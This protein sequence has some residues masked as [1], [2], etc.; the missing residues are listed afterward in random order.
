MFKPSEKKS[1]KSHQLINQIF[2]EKVEDADKY[3]V[4]YAYYMKRGIFSQ[5]MY[6]YIIGFSV[7]DKEIIVIPI[8]S[9]TNESGDAIN[10]TKEN[11]Q[12]AKYG[13]QGDV[14][15]KS[16][17]L[18]KDLRFMVPGFTPPSLENAYVL[19]ILQEDAAVKFKAFIKENL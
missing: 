13:L 8:T 12:S 4:V 7:P 14:K 11:I 10:L 6:S 17:I 5:T 3:T 1:Q 2:I 16:D 15:I 18:E 9:D 19:P